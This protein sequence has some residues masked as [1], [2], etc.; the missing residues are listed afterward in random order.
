MMAPLEPRQ[1]IFHDSKVELCFRKSVEWLVLFR[2]NLGAFHGIL[3]LRVGR[4][5]QSFLML[6]ERREM[7]VDRCWR[8]ILKRYIP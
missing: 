7:G 3:T 5:H 6:H 8:Q 4:Q 1:P 2:D